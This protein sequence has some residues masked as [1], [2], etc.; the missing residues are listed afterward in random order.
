MSASFLL[1][2][3]A[4]LCYF[5]GNL[6]RRS[7]SFLNLAIAC[8]TS[9][10]EAANILYPRC[11]ERLSNVVAITLYRPIAYV[12]RTKDIERVPREPS[13]SGASVGLGLIEF[14]GL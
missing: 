3:S 9:R 1:N 8:S 4:R 6:E 10:R 7:M 2:T 11:R 12:R 14:L 13:G 5:L